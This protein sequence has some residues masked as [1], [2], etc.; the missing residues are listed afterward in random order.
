[1][2]GRV[3]RMADSWHCNT[4]AKCRVWCNNIDVDFNS[5][6]IALQWR[7]NGRH[8]ISNH[9]HHDCLLKRLFRRRS[10]KTSKL[11]VTGLRAGNSPVTGEFPVQMTNN[12]ENVSIWWRQ[13]GICFIWHGFC[14][15][16]WFDVYL[17]NDFREVSPCSPISHIAKYGLYIRNLT[18][19]QSV[20]EC[21]YLKCI[22]LLQ[23]T[24]RD[25]FISLG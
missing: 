11:R 10:N 9:Q 2:P 5:R 16:D 21:M 24:R 7:H 8:C 17:Q 6:I 18:Y 20:I 14:Y 22:L 23:I 1:M 15:Y 12:A 4:K 19:I 13:Y 25:H 3:M